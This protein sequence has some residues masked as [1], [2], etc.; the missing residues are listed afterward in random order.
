MIFPGVYINITYNY[1]Y[2][3]LG[4]F[5]ECAYFVHIDISHLMYK[6]PLKCFR[7]GSEFIVRATTELGDC[8][9]QLH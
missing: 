5:I 8:T 1:I 3:G 9:M 7:L 4:T 2:V 6:P